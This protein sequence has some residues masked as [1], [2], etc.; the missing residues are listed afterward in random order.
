[1]TTAY[2]SFGANLAACNADL[3]SVLTNVRLRL[4][5]FKEIGAIRASR[6]FRTP[7]FPPGSGPDFLN[8]AMTFPTTLAP[9]ALLEI[10]HAIEHD[11]GRTRTRRWEPRACDLDLLGLGDAILPDAATVRRWMA[12]TDAEA[13]AEM[14]DRLLLPHPRMH[15]RGFVLVPLAD[16]AADWRHP[17]LGRTVAEMLGDLDPADLAEIRPW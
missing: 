16:V 2:V 15:R 13:M 11:M 8:A 1:M 12:M 14:P 7:A 6:A 5:E 10:L 9:A 17:V 4:A 3:A